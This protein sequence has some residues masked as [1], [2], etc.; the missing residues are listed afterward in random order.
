MKFIIKKSLSRKR[1]RSSVPQRLRS[2]LP[3]Q[4]TE[5]PFTLLL[6]KEDVVLSSTVKKALDRLD[7]SGNEPIVVIARELTIEGSKLLAE[8]GVLN[9]S[10]SSFGWLDQRYKAITQGWD[11]EKQR[12]EYGKRATKK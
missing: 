4:L 8:K 3:A 2:L 11:L 7:E 9:M 5:G 10:P 1:L 12:D 6:F